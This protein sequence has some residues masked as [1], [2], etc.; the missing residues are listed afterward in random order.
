MSEV[1]RFLDGMMALYP[2]HYTITLLGFATGLRASSMRPLRRLGPTP[3]VLWDDGVL[4][5]RQS[6]TR[7]AEVDVQSSTK[8]GTRYRISLPAELM[9]VLRWHVASLPEGP[10]QE[11]DLLFPAT[12]GRF[13]SASVLDRP[14]QAV[15]THVG[16]RRS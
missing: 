1:P 3:D 9:E 14:F 13:R 8:Q 5:I 12:T 11:S 16:L 10:Q 2:G 4:L 6:H 7:G 15:A